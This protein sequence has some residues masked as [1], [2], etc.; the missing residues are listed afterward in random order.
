[1]VSNTPPG[2]YAFPRLAQD[3]WG[4]EGYAGMTLRD[5]AALAV[6]P[7]CYAEADTVE[8]AAKVAFKAADAWLA[9]RS[10]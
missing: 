6:F 4:N 10:K 5:A 7:Q 3:A 8:S 2:G 1:V 9:E